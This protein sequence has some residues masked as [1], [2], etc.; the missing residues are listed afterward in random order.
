MGIE[1]KLEIDSTEET[2]EETKKTS[3][4]VTEPI[5]EENKLDEKLTTE[6]IKEPE[7]KEETKE[8]KYLIKV[9][10]IEK[11]LTKEEVLRMAQKATAAEERFDEA[12]KMRE[13]IEQLF[14][15]LKENPVDIISKLGINFEQLAEQYLIEK[16]KY[17]QMSE[18]ERKNLDYERKL[19]E[20]EQREETYKQQQQE[21]AN[22][23]ETKKY[24]EEY[25]K[26][27]VEAIEKSTLPK[28][29][30][31]VQRMAGYVYNAKAKGMD[32]NFDEAAKLVEEDI[33][34]ELKQVYGAYKG[35][36]L[37][38]ALGE[39]IVKEIRQHDLSKIKQPEGKGMKKENTLPRKAQKQK[40]WSEFKEEINSII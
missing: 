4:Q 3:D 2:Q 20:H 22:N 40:K 9:N 11:E 32:M 29:D 1:S 28:N 38:N 35:E 7:K 33:K 17:Q 37:Y 36:Q 30:I 18:V 23:A 5:K 8:E 39:D 26:Q 19:K 27:I 31:I 13:Q 24:T 25:T 6:P 12:S 10:G 21:A 14:G 16:L 15:A 34:T